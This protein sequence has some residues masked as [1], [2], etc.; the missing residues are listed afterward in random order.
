MFFLRSPTFSY[1]FFSISIRRIFLNFNS[2]VYE[3]MRWIT[4]VLFCEAYL[5]T[6]KCPKMIDNVSSVFSTNYF[7]FISYVYKSPRNNI[8][9]KF[10]EKYLCLPW[11]II[12]GY[13]K[14]NAGHLPT[15]CLGYKKIAKSELCDILFSE[16]GQ[17]ITTPSHECKGHPQ[18]LQ[19]GTLFVKHQQIIS[20]ARKTVTYLTL[21][22]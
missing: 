3:F 17:R 12:T 21:R 16:L 1:T 22:L 8:Q 19:P 13:H 6:I 11:P 20:W 4:F 14:I 10:S 7:L 2:F 18:K 15:L 5:I 9:H